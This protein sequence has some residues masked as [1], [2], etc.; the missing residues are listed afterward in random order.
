[1]LLV[2]LYI[3]EGTYYVLAFTSVSIIQRRVKVMSA[4]PERPNAALHSSFLLMNSK[5]RDTDSE[6]YISQHH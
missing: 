3:A 5:P 2:T 1:M 6:I 4:R